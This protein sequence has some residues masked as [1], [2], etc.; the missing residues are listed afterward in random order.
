[1]AEDKK[2]IQLKVVNSAVSGMAVWLSI[3]DAAL[4]VP[5]STCCSLLQKEAVTFRVKTTT[6][7]SK[8]LAAYC[9]KNSLDA[10][11]K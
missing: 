2:T 10:C 8:I 4:V 3:V 6:K 7:F 1:M 9:Q 5:R 11:T